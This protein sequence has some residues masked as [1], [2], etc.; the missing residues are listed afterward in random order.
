MLFP[1]PGRKKRHGMLLET[2]RDGDRRCQECGGVCCSSFASVEITWEE[3]ERLKAL[4]SHR[5]QLSLYGP[6]RLEI[7]Y[8]CEFLVSGR[9]SIYNQRPE[10]CRRFTCS[11]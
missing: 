3:Y 4:G 6:H 7:D 5:L 2:P 8:G 9:C 10:I 11:D 1:A